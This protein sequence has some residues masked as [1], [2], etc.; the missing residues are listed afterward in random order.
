MPV[1]PINIVISGIDKFSRNFG[2]ASKSI[3]RFGKS[4][5]RVGR[6]MTM[7]LT[8]PLAIMGASTLKTAADFETSMNRV[9]NLTKATEAQM[10][11][12][13]RT[14]RE[15][16]AT[17][18]FTASE[19]AGAMGFLGMAGFEA[20]KIIGAMPGTLQLAAAAQMDLAQAADIASNIMTPFNMKAEEMVRVS[21]VLTETFQ[22]TNTS[23][24]QLAEAM[25]YVAPIASSA[26]VAFEETSAAI[27]L[28]GNA[29]IQASMAGTTLRKAISSIIKPTS[30]AKKVFQKLNIPKNQ[31]I[32]A[33]GNVRSL[34]TVIEA[35]EKSGAS[36]ADIMAIF[37]QRAG[38][39]MAA[40][41]TQGSK[42]LKD[43]TEQVEDSSGA[44]KKAADVNMKGLNGQLKK[45]RSAFEELQLAIADSGLLE[46]ATR[47][48]GK[49]TVM[50]RKL[51]QLNPTI[52][53]MATIFGMVLAAIG[54]ILIIVGKIAIAIGAIGPVVAKLGVAFGAIKVAV[55]AVASAIGVLGA[56]IIAAVGIWAYN[57]Y[58]IKQGWSEVVS[59]FTDWN[60][61]L[62]TAKI[63]IADIGYS[64][65]RLV[66]P[67]F[68]EKKFGLDQESVE[69][70]RYEKRMAN[71]DKI[72]ADMRSRDSKVSATMSF[73]NVPR[74][75]R[76]IERKGVD[77]I[78]MQ[79]GMNFAG[80]L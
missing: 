39:G 44:A 13:S 80:G 25:V 27:G 35:L 62:E 5:E 45:L 28:L 46:W 41:L 15:L 74:G 63:M 11:Q 12:M 23:M 37:G 31:L 65:G 66:L 51:S 40:L 71:R 69:G 26:G 9:Q 24:E 79:Y 1:P 19:A 38:P 34:A 54:P 73:D 8:V 20:N 52:L 18:Q 70:R 72:L 47:F 33:E 61:A 16:G 56:L 67:K 55:I 57:I 14:A 30:E 32:D 42:A 36:T 2:A 4:A 58:Q 76:I 49:L 53:K 7:G 6:S 60:H 43:M 50:V 68:L 77:D 17:T 10:S 64:L 22:S 75:A 3:T 48:V 59:V 29:G 78:N 21:D